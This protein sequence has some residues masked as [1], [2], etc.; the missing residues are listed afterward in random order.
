MMDDKVVLRCGG[1]GRQRGE[2]EVCA[3]GANRRLQKATRSMLDAEW[4][5]HPPLALWFTVDAQGSIGAPAPDC[6]DR[7]SKQWR[8]AAALQV[9]RYI[10]CWSQHFSFLSAVGRAGV[11]NSGKN[12]VDG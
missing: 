2:E 12:I 7:A 8:A 4:P 3:L 10:S 9:P 6:P 1:G 5:R 11:L